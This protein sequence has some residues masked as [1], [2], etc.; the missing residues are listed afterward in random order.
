MKKHFPMPE[1]LK[2]GPAKKSSKFID[3]VKETANL[4]NK[5]NV[6]TILWIMNKKHQR[7]ILRKV[8][9]V[10]RKHT[11]PL[12]S[13]VDVQAEMAKLKGSSVCTIQRKIYGGRG[14]KKRK[15][16]TA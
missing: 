9:D 12:Y 10:M 15:T 11:F 14:K 2:N 13:D 16:G 3:A 7:S 5:Y 4:V 8:Y 6:E 1:S